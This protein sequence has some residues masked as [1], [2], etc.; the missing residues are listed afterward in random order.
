[1]AVE[2]NLTTDHDEIRRW[3]ESVGGQP[4]RMRISGVGTEVE[5]PHI[6]FG[7]KPTDNGPWAISWDDWFTMFDD[8]GLALLYERDQNGGSTSTFNKLVPRDQG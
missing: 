1:M 5:V 6:D 7:R 8:A 3:A 4:T 2:I